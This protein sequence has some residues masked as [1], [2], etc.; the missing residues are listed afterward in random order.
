M[1]IVNDPVLFLY[2]LN[3]ALTGACFVAFVYWRIKNRK[4]SASY[5]YRAIMWLFGA[6]VF[7]T[8][9]NALARTMY[10]V[11]DDAYH[12]VM[13][14]TFWWVRELLFA[15]VLV[16]ITYWVY[17]RILRPYEKVRKHPMKDRR[18]GIKDRRT[19]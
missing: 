7:K 9:C 12:M 14:S 8:G 5:M 11:D 18:K 4:V 10:H 15:V 19:N 3:F 16:T 17:G 2:Y 1:S 6:M 13:T